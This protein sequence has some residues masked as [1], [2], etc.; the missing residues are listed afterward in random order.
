MSIQNNIQ[1][2]V[3]ACMKSGN[4]EKR[5]AL[6]MIASALKNEVINKGELSE[7]QE[8]EILSREFKRLKDSL[9]E[10]EQANRAELVE[11]TKKEMEY[12]L[13]FMPA[14]ASDEE[15]IAKAKEMMASGGTDVN[16]LMGPLMKEFKGKAD[17]TRV[18]E[19]VMKLVQG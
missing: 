12:V 8:V 17:G 6:R 11:K 14:Q 7:E 18:R 15:I 2:E 10:F 4:T 3:I 16:K 5:D 9:Q 1:A 13:A 19:I